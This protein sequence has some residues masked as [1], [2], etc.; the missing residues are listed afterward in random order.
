[1]LRGLYQ[2]LKYKN[3]F[4]LKLSDGTRRAGEDFSTQTCLGFQQRRELRKQTAEDE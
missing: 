4:S 3:E 2:S 1:M